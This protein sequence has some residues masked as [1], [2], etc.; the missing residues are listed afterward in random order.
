MEANKV[1]M[2]ITCSHCKK[3]Y[4][5]E[6]FKSDLNDY[7]NNGKLVQLAF[8]YLSDGERELIISGICDTCFTDMFKDDEE[9]EE[10]QDD[11]DELLSLIYSKSNK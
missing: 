10:H 8:P 4:S 2:N 3:T 9:D 11:A 6:V 5:L 7:I 1:L